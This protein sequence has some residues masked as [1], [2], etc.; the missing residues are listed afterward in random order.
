MSILIE[1]LIGCGCNVQEAM[2][3]FLNNEDFYAKC[4]AKFIED[5]SFQKLGDAIKA[6]DAKAAFEAAH[7]LK[8][9]SANMG[10]TPVYDHVVGIVEDFR[11]G[12]MPENA[13]GTWEQIMELK[14]KLKKIME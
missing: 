10:I 4:Y 6:G 14:E 13:L 12:R 7:E 11:E 8:G 5:K 3:R 2:S 1:R 9:I